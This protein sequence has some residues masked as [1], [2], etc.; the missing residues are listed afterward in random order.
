MEIYKKDP[1][2]SPLNT[3]YYGI[4]FF[5]YFSTNFIATVSH[6]KVCLSLSTEKK[7]S[8]CIVENRNNKVKVLCYWH[9]E[10]T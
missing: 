7:P 1:H 5:H 10:F 8:T 2:K 4:C 3:S 9:E 6:M